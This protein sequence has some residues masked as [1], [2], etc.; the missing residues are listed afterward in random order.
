MNKTTVLICDDNIAVHESLCLYLHDAGISVIST[1]DGESAL[2]ELRTHHVDLVILD[3]MLPKM[4]GT[5]VC[6]EIRKTSDVPIIMLSARGEEVDRIMGLQI[7]ADDYISK[8]FS[9]REVVVRVQTILRRTIKKP[10]N[11]KLT[12]AELTVDENAY[13]CYLGSKKLDLP[14]REVEVLAYF[15]KNAGIALRRERILN[16]VWGY[17]YFGDTRAVDTQISRL[18]KKLSANGASFDIISVYGVGYRLE[19]K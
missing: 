12:F 5:E 17:E 3:L 1:Y 18:R 14:P 19:K 16:A 7:G 6:T 9:P 15:V 2:T 4:L 10:E 11:N 13:I 8:P